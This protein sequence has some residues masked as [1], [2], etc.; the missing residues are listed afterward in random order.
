M[1]IQEQTYS[2]KND[3]FRKAVHAMMMQKQMFQDRK[4]MQYRAK[5]ERQRKKQ[6]R[7]IEEFLEKELQRTVLRH[8]E[9]S[10]PKTATNQIGNRLKEEPLTSNIAEVAAMSFKKKYERV[11]QRNPIVQKAENLDIF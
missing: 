4:A 10:K 7:E 1:M 9:L 3:N 11:R 6:E 5:L 8:R 2:E